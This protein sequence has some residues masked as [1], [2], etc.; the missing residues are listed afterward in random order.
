MVI[1]LRNFAAGVISMF[2]NIFPPLVVFGW[3]GWRGMPIEI[4]S[5][6]TASISMGI[7]VDDTIHYL[8][9]Y[10]RGVNENLDRTE[11]IIYAH[12][13]CAKSM[14]D[15]TMICGLGTAPFIFSVFMPTVR[16][17]VLMAVLL[18]VGLLGDLI[19][20]PAMLKGPLGYF[21]GRKT[22]AEEPI[23]LAAEILPPKFAG[24]KEP[25]QKL[26]ESGRS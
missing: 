1:L 14:I 9:W 11:S 25:S 20:L 6:M 13:H 19:L 15:T 3:M 12:R 26:V 17:A 5:V 16:F 10:R 21:F 22:K 4:G 23:E 7:A 18:G 24:P 2:P 8:A